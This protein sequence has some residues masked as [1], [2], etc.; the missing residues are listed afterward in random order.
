MSRNAPS[1]QKLRGGYYTP[2]DIADFLASWAIRSKDDRILE[3]SCGD[4]IFLEAA[5]RRLASLGAPTKSALSKMTAV[6]L[7]PNEYEKSRERMETLV[8]GD[9]DQLRI[10]RS[11]FF[12]LFLKEL[13]TQQ[14]DAVIGNP[15]FIRYQHFNEAVRERALKI[16]QKAGVKA[17][18]LMNM[19]MP[20]LVA[21]SLLLEKQGRLAMIIPAELLQVNYAAGLRTFLS[22]FYSLI[23]IISFRKLIFP[24]IQQEVVLFLG[25][26]VNG[27]H[28][29]N[30]VELN[31]ASE[32]EQYVHG[33][34]RADFK[35]VDHTTDKWTQY[36]LSRDEI[37]LLRKFQQDERIKKLGDLAEVDVGVV[38]GRNEFFVVSQP[39]LD[40]YDISRYAKPIVARTSQLKGFIFQEEDWE[41]NNGGGNNANLL[42]FVPKQFGSLSKAAISYILEGEKKGFHKGYKCRIRDPWYVVPAIWKPDAF[43]FRQIYNGPRLVLNRTEATVTDTLHRV[44]LKEGVKGEQVASCFHNSLTFAFAEIM[45][46]S[47]GGGVLELEPREAEKLPIPYLKCDAGLLKRFDMQ[48]RKDSSL[49]GMLDMTDEILLRQQ[50]ELKST[51]IA[52]LRRIWKKLSQRRLNRKF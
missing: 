31:D 49:D 22:E 10:S 3:P 34:A 20:F 2:S 29:I 16:L 13:Q 42:Y 40:R 27:F 47:Y 12:A 46:R 23:T 39:I 44:R 17:N 35:P 18:K 50:L 51:E 48:L 7:D 52:M 33:M 32:L 30:V 14:F 41:Q 21:S 15:P 25:E 19:W 36:F 9:I 1:K 43:L 28:G 8:D 24:E 4:G 11:D 26:K 37:L 5:Y 6:E 38:T 45:G